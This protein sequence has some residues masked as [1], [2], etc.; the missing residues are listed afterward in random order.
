MKIEVMNCTIK[1][2]NNEPWYNFK[3]NLLNVNISDKESKVKLIE[4]IKQ[5]IESHD[6]SKIY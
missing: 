5:L 3:C 1:R 6:F 2:A 4:E